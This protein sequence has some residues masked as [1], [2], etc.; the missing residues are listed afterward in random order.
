MKQ[1]II[2]GL[3][4]GFV[5]IALL[6]LNDTSRLCFCILASFLVFFEYS[7]ITKFK[8]LDYIFCLILLI[9][10]TILIYTIPIGVSISLAIA[11]VINSLLILNLKTGSNAIH[12][13]TRFITASIYIVVPFVLVYALNWYSDKKALF[14][15]A[16]FLTW[17]ADSG[18]YFVGSR[19]GINKIAPTI[20][21]G[22]SWEG[23]LGAGM[24]S[25]IFI[26][27]FGSLIGYY[28]LSQWFLF[29]IIVW[30]F[31]LLGDLVASQVKRMTGVKD[32]GSLLPGHG[33]FYDRF[34]AFIFVLPFV[35]V[36]DYLIN[37]W[38]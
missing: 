3:I 37:I 29:A 5:V 34:D 32:S 9:G 17:V 18:A 4:F 35:M 24:L 2:T 19:I 15:A 22:K 7:R 20:S 33:G 6:L 30:A 1:R 38:L 14:L 10:V 31:G 23:F 25:L 21:P 12:K 28:T 11:F 13:K 16:I 36:F 8:V 27:I 26:Y